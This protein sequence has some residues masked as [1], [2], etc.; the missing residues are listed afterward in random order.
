MKI[1]TFFLLIF[2]SFKTYSQTVVEMEKYN[3]V[4]K[5]ECKINGI[6]M[7]FIFDT[8]ASNVS[9]SST[10]ALF[11]IKQGLI[12][13]E[14]VI[15]NVN[16]RIANGKTLEGTK[17]NLKTI[18]IQGLVLE[19][20]TA[21]V[22][23]ELNSPLLL[24]QSV[25]SRLGKISIEEN[26]LIIHNE[27]SI[28]TKN[29]EKELTETVEWLNQKIQEYQFNGKFKAEYI[30]SLV[31]QKGDFYIKILQ[32]FYLSGKKL[33]SKSTSYIPINEISNIYFSK[34]GYDFDTEDKKGYI[35]KITMKND[36]HKII[37]E[38][39]SY[40]MGESTKSE[41]KSYYVIN[42]ER[43]IDK[44]DLQERMNKAFD[45][46]KELTQTKVKKTK[47]KF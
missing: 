44:E 42:L 29:T 11:L 13:D 10:E 18:E 22:V 36:N 31:K 47:E 40:F 7:D 19:N 27:S 14:D 41:T 15:G 33:T 9:I 37:E 1:T 21:T 2:L 8:G 6:P 12:T 45:Y 28:I 3:G 23:H 34:R 35:L 4:Y 25:L 5:L 43:S 17:I 16:Y 24:G 20:V 26:K 38:T 30:L 46:L 32:D 39:T